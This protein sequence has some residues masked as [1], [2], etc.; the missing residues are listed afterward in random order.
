M[1]ERP[2]PQNGE[3]IRCLRKIRDLSQGDLADKAGVSQVTVH[4]LETESRAG[5]F[6]VLNRVAAAL[7]VPLGAILRERFHTDED[8][9]V[10]S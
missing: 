2:P 6:W 7:D 10:A 1:P 4:Y 3:T 8:T 5:S 9:A